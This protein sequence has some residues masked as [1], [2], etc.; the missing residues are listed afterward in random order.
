VTSTVARGYYQMATIATGEDMIS[1]N[2][3]AT[4]GHNSDVRFSDI[5]DKSLYKWVI[6]CPLL[7]LDPPRSLHRR[8]VVVA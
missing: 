6:R 5:T 8:F 4:K 1:P 2:T 7:K 3:I